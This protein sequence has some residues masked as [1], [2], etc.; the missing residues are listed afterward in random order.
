MDYIN[1]LGLKALET[2]VDLIWVILWV[3]FGIYGTIKLYM[4][5]RRN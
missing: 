5:L 1:M 3:C 4:W 2:T